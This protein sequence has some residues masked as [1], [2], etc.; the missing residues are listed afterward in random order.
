MTVLTEHTNPKGKLAKRDAATQR[1]GQA[2]S[3]HAKARDKKWTAG[4]HQL[5]GEVRQETL[6]RQFILLL[7]V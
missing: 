6:K 1:D 3:V 4:Y 2:A 7:S 5:L